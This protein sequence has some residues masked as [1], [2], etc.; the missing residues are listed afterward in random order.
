MRG[1]AFKP[2]ESNNDDGNNNNNQNK[3]AI[4]IMDGRERN[5]ERDLGG[6]RCNWITVVPLETPVAPRWQISTLCD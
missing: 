6:R 3:T 5:V 4:I 1:E 2:Y